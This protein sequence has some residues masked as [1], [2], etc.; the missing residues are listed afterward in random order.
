MLGCLVFIFKKSKSIKETRHAW[1]LKF[2]DDFDFTDNSI[3]L[4]SVL[5]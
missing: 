1:S 4:F 5:S 2:I 3:A